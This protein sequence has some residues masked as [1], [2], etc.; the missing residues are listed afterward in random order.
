M[1]R[2]KALDLLSHAGLTGADASTS[3]SHALVG[4]DSIDDMLL[5][6]QTMDAPTLWKRFGQ[7]GGRAV[8]ILRA[9][10]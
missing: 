1:T 5:E 8:V 9:K 6:A 10:S 3:L 2:E 7:D 4:F